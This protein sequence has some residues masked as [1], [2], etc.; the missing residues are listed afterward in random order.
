[1]KFAHILLAGAAA[2]AVAAPAIADTCAQPAERTALE[3]HALQSHLA[4]VAIRCRQDDNYRTFVERHRGELTG[5]YRTSVTYFRRAYGAQG[6]RR[7]DMYSTELANAHDQ[8]AARSEAFLCRDNAALYQQVMG[9]TSDQLARLTVERNI[10]TTMSPDACA[11]TPA[12]PA[13]AT[14]PARRAR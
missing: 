7:F 6:V 5:A 1:M 13:R 8:D 14:R 3:L 2:L 11:A 4:V 9:G 12:R 10:V